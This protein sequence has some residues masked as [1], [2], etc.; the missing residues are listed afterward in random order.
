MPKNRMQ[1]IYNGKAERFR[2]L[3]TE[4]INYSKQNI[5]INFPSD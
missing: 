3:R 1:F 2:K 4:N 5:N